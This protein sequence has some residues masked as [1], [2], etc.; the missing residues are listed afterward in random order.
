[1]ETFFAGVRSPAG[2]PQRKCDGDEH[3]RVPIRK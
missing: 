2:A 1:V 3:L